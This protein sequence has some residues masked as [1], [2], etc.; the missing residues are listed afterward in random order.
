MSGL[1]Y[2]QLLN[3]LK[4]LEVDESP[5]LDATVTI[6]DG[7]ADEY[8]QIECIMVTH[9]NDVLDKDHPYL[10]ESESDDIPKLVDPVYDAIREVPDIDAPLVCLKLH[11]TDF[12]DPGHRGADLAMWIHEWHRQAWNDT[13]EAVDWLLERG[14][15]TFSDDGELNCVE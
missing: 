14:R 7:E 11:D 9:E 3:W 4:I 1:T 6:K 5:L 15:I 10:L 12:V 8:T 13:C 2:R